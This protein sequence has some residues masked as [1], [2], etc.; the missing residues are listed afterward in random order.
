M[1]HFRIGVDIGGTFTDIVFLGGDGRVLTRKVASTPDDYSRAV[2]NGIRAGMEELN[3]P[4]SSVTEV[5]H[6]FTVA[7]NAIIEEKG[8]HMAL[9]TTEGFRDVLEFRRNRTPR[10]YDLYYEKSPTLVKRQ[11]RLEVGERLNFRGEVLRPIDADSVD[12]AAQAVVDSGVESVAVCLLHSYAN[13][14]HEQVVAQ[15][16]RERAPDVVLTL[17]SDLL[18]EMKEYERTSTTV[19]NSYVRP[20]VETYLTLLTQGLEDMGI[21]VP[22]AVMQSNGG[23]ATSAIA[24][25]R[26]VYCIESGPAAGVVGAFH[27]GRRLD[28]PNLDDPR[29]GRHDSQASIIENGEMLQAP[30][31]EVGGDISVGHRLLRGSGHILRV[32]AIDLAEVGAGGGSIATVDRSGSLRVGPQ[33]SGAFPG[34]ACYQLGGQDATV[35]D[36]DVLLGYLNPQHLL[37]GDFPIDSELARR[38]VTD[39]VAR[40]LNMSDVEAAHGIHLL[41]NS[42][43]GRALRAV[44]SE[45][46]RDPRRFDLICF[47]GGGPVHAAGL[48]EMLDITRVVV[49]PFPGVFSSF[50]LLVADV[51]HHFVRTHF[52]TFEEIDLPTL[53]AWSRAC[54]RRAGDSSASRVS[55]LT[56]AV[57]SGP[58][59]QATLDAL[60]ENF[61]SEHEQSFGYR[62]DVGYQLVNIRVIARGLPDAP[63][64]P[65]RFELADAA[66]GAQ[67]TRPVYF[68]PNRGWA[69]TP[70]LSRPSLQGRSEP[71]PLV[72]EEYDSTTVVPPTWAATVDDA[73]NIILERA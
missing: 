24:M 13:P 66:N 8:A 67:G 18:P 69:D 37:A 58:I 45:R 57:P 22:L 41:V 73:S 53:A 33:S 12:R 61:D 60:A 72:I 63:R 55:D 26:P 65:E 16:V 34:P 44:S 9:I 59:T 10:L 14:A 36:A 32:P 17:S 6:G 31:Y 54:G 21:T 52:K 39:N 4:P 64:M 68:G 3:I 25:E 51:E 40:P 62:T 56:V 1:P 49:P 28:M 27:L 5:G 19:I 15:A 42:N 38:A 71:G 70:V 20:V 30:E 23:L 48:A 11:Y 2:L 47:G 50:G 35:T 46:G 29:H 43:M 7:T